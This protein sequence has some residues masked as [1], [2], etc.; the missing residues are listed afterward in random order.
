[1]VACVVIKHLNCVPVSRHEVLEHDQIATSAQRRSIQLQ[2]RVDLDAK[3][4][5]I[6]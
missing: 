1:M 3:R 4:V 6:E 5:C 2:I